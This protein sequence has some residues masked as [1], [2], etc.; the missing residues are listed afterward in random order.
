MLS[1]LSSHI[2]DP[3]SA[4]ESTNTEFHYFEI[5]RTQT[6]RTDQYSSTSFG[7][8]S[9]VYQASEP[10]RWIISDIF[11]RRCSFG[12]TGLC[13]Y[14]AFSSYKYRTMQC[15]CTWTSEADVIG[16]FV[17]AAY[18]RAKKKRPK[19]ANFVAGCNFSLHISQFE[20]N[21][22]Q[23]APFFTLYFSRAK[24]V[25]CEKFNKIFWKTA[26]H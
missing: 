3:I 16:N 26:L 25:G 19:I 17:C 2:S 12:T 10:L 18:R 14:R 5:Y 13:V 24:Q 20:A 4:S 22:R 6:I 15:C 9:A 7:L 21:Y 11:V 23:I 8:F 1:F